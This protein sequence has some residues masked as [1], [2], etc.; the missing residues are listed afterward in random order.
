MTMPPRDSVTI[1][2][3]VGL[4]CAALIAWGVI[5]VTLIDLDKVLAFS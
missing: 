3:R 2:V 1:C 5:L 4:A